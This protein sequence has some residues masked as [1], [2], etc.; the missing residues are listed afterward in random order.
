MDSRSCRRDRQMGEKPLTAKLYSDWKTADF[1]NPSLLL[2]LSCPYTE[3]F[4][5]F[6]GMRQVLSNI[7][8][9]VKL[10]VLVLGL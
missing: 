4:C 7:Y 10:G 5:S 8:I 6:C 1:R 3:F 2:A 9:V